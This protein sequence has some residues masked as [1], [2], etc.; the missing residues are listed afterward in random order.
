[1][2]A[3]DKQTEKAPI[4]VSKSFMT[5]GPTLHYSHQNV[6]I[7][8][9][10]AIAAFCVSCLFWSKIQTGEFWSFDFGGIASGEFWHLGESDE[11]IVSMFQYPWQIL[12]L[13]LLM[14]ILAVVP[15]L[16]SQLLSFGYSLPF[17][18]AV[19]FLANL[20]AFAIFVLVSCFGA[21]CRPLRFRSRITAIA[22]C[23]APQLLYW[24]LFGGAKGVEPTQWGLS[25]APWICAWLIGL[26]I[27][28]LVLGIGHFTRYRPGLVWTFTTVFFVLA[29]VT[30]EIRIGF[31]ELDYQLLVARNIPEET[32]EQD[33]SI[34]AA[35]DEVTT[36][37]A[38]DVKKYFSSFSYP[39]DA[40]QLRVRLKEELQSELQ[41]Y[42]SWP[43]W[44]D[45]SEQW[46]Y[47][48]EKQWLVKQYDEF[49]SVQGESRRLPIALY[50]KGILSEYS[51]DI[52]LLGEKEVLHFYSDYP[53]KRSW[54]VWYRLYSKYGESAE[55][56]EARWRVAMHLA[57]QGYFEEAGGLLGEAQ[58]GLSER[59]KEREKE[60]AGSKTVFSLFRPPAETVMTRVKLEEL[61]RRLNQ[62][63][64]LIGEQNRTGEA[65]AA[66]RLARFVMLN[67]HTGD[68]AR[69]LVELLKQMGDKDRL[70]D[71]VL[72][73]QAK[74]V[75]DKQRRAEKLAELQKEFQDTDGGMQ[76]LYELARLKNG[77][78]Q[79]EEDAEQRKK[80]LADAKAT[81]TRFM[82]LYPES[83]CAEQVKAILDGLPAN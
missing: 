49:I 62:L 35:L 16:V 19:C 18:L 46:D 43:M 75:A 21:V 3:D 42:Q 12:V 39:T 51:P 76:A 22:L 14:G 68:Y 60:Q 55:S 15:V 66:R 50:Y 32:I 30:F 10:L 41:Y 23:M 26:G 59:L 61:Q 5:V 63:R 45:V 1:M 24:G 2:T 78:Y 33:Q 53:Y 69:Q 27:A 81:L 83:F 6:Q 36:N 74:L 37:P 67:P 57:G 71:N 9:L 38:D 80:Y 82:R 48:S 72:L 79:G 11:T 54:G 73:A 56:L 20:P 44:F 29:I 77:L 58:A 13:G 65:A 34:A 4:V 70:R 64:S 31:D 25:F 17:I 8:W 7:C 52:R 40:I 28:G 47:K